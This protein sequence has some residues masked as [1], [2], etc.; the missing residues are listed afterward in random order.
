MGSLSTALSACKQLGG[1]NY[2]KENKTTTPVI[3]HRHYVDPDLCD[4]EKM[5][6]S[7]AGSRIVGRAII[8]CLSFLPLALDNL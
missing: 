4:Y 7:S 8:A 1:E 6:G 5:S 3:S 2:E